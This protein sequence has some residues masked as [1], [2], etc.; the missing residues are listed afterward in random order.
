LQLKRYCALLLPFSD[1]GVLT[2]VESH[3]RQ[4]MRLISLSDKQNDTEKQMS[5]DQD[6]ADARYQTGLKDLPI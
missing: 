2:M 3:P 6:M 4:F 1:D 5:R